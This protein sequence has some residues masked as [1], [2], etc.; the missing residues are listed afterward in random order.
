MSIQSIGDYAAKNQLR[1]LSGKVFDSSRVTSRLVTRRWTDGGTTT[2]RVTSRANHMWEVDDQ[3]GQF[4]LAGPMRGLPLSNFPAFST[5]SHVLRSRGFKILSPAEKDIKAGF[6]V[7][8]PVSEQKF[9]M[10]AAFRWDFKAVVDSN[11]IILMPGWEHSTGAKAERL[12][13]QLCELEVYLLDEK[14]NLTEAPPVDYEL[15]WGNLVPDAPHF[16]DS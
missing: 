5:A 10:G 9:D 3:P 2:V 8:R 14:F 15:K 12:V 11:G 16:L 4:Y 6:D 7:S 13:A 1:E